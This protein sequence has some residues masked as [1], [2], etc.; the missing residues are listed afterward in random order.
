[1]TAPQI[2]HEH[3]RETPVFVCELLVEMLTAVKLIL[4]VQPIKQHSLGDW[5]FVLT[6]LDHKLMR[7]TV[8]C[9]RALTHLRSHSEG[10]LESTKNTK[11]DS[12]RMLSSSRQ[13]LQYKFG[14]LHPVGSGAE[15][16]QFP[17][18]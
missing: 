3:R 9:S 7:G 1:M 18:H 14:M 12:G 2:I 13:D 5:M 17:S 8:T 4:G 15:Y 6:D 11:P 10:I 16:A